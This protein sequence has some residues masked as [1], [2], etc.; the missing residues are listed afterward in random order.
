MSYAYKTIVFQGA[1]KAGEFYDQGQVVEHD[2]S[3]WQAT[4]GVDGYEPSSVSEC[5]EAVEPEQPK[6]SKPARI[7]DRPVTVGLLRDI[8]ADFHKTIW[9]S[10]PRYEGVWK[11]GKTYTPGAF[12]THSGS[13]FHAN[14]DSA[15]VKPGQGGPEWT[16]AVKAGK[17]AR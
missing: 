12:V 13:L 3:L 2:G 4:I 9:K 7:E 6:A 14:E 10:L 16:L 15:D 8:L 17:D 5:W 1:W 11:A